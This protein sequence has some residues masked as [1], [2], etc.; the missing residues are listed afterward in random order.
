MKYS[1]L[2]RCAETEKVEA[3]LVKGVR[4]LAIKREQVLDCLKGGLRPT[5]MKKMIHLLLHRGVDKGPEK[6]FQFWF[7]VATTK[8]GKAVNKVCVQ[9]KGGVVRIADE[10]GW[11]FSQ[12][13]KFAGPKAVVS[14]VPIGE[15]EGEVDRIFEHTPGQ[16]ECGFRFAWFP[17]CLIIM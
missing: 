4:W 8:H 11:C 7:A 17:E 10:L 5:S 3:T 2:I 12:I 15:A 14:G 6:A 13:D 9:V 16:I 1:P